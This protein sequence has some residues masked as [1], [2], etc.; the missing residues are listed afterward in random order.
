MDPS[1]SYIQALLSTPFD[2]DVR[3]SL[4]YLS[5]T[6]LMAA[7][8]WRLRGA[9]TPF[10]TWLLP[11]AVY[12]HRSNILDIKLF[13]VN[14]ILSVTGVFGAVVFAPLITFGVL[15]L[16]GGGTLEISDATLSWQ[17][18]LL[19][20]VIIVMSTDFCKYWNH[21]IHH[22]SRVL[23][24]FHAV[25]HSAEVLTPLTLTR[26]HPME[27]IIRNL[28]ISVLVGAVQALL[29]YVFVA[30]IDLVTI[31]GANAL[32]FLFNALGSNLRH[33]HIWLSYGRVLEHIFISPAQHQVHHSMAVEHHNKNYGSIFA[34][35]DWMFGTLYVPDG[36]EELK[37][38]VAGADGV[39]IEEPHKDL[40]S[41]LV[42]PFVMA[43]RTL[44]RT[45]KSAADVLREGDEA[46]A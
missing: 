17:Q 23:W 18:S 6:I 20:T 39:P 35:W 28:I 19:A 42:T 24:F 1:Q 3:Y 10:L 38:G 11:R 44:T 30:K 27:N 43:W 13:F 4:I 29:L 37:F 5:A 45:R 9:K 8:I 36:Y 7:L 22:E 21:R 40:H 2:L 34:L 31:G 41:A 33:S 12:T 16:L 15:G 32:Y 25:H 26:A 46:E 14:R